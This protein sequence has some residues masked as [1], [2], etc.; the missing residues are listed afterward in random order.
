MRVLN[1]QG[2]GEDFFCG[3]NLPMHL[4]KTRCLNEWRR[5]CER[6]FRRALIR[7]GHISTGNGVTAVLTDSRCNQHVTAKGTFE[8]SVRLPAA[9]WAVKNAG[10]GNKKTMPLITEIGEAYM[11]LAEQTVIPMA[12]KSSYL[13]R[14][15]KRIASLP[16]DARG[17][18]LSEDSDGEGGEDTGKFL[19]MSSIY[20]WIISLM[21]LP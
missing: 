18:P 4:N 3:L 7:M 9:I 15:K 19:L 14:L 2:Q 11:K 10:A 5:C 17:E 12:H 20:L 16:Q 1:T 6:I 21:A 13:R 8:R